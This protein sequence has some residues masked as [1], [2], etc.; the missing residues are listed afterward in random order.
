MTR[1]KLV[2]VFVGGVMCWLGFNE[3]TVGEGASPEPQPVELAELEAGAVPDNTHLEVGPHWRMYQELVF[4]YETKR[5][6]SEDDVT[7]STVVD[8]AYFPALSPSHPYFQSLGNLLTLYGDFD[9]IPEEQLPEVKQIALLV[10][11]KQHK[12]V[13]SLP[14][15]SWAQAESVR[16]LVINR[17]HELTDDERSL[18]EQS[19]PD[20][21]LESVLVLEEG[22][23]P[24]SAA[25][26]YGLMGGGAGVSLAGIGWLL[27]GFR[28]RDE[29]AVA[30]E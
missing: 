21:S 3:L 1:L 14:D 16:G 15:A 9:A 11:T 17:I 4:S 18:I 29:D 22:R 25:K 5:G 24:A 10:K 30:S 6:A 7:D 12:T 8:Y 27:V 20:L 28:R 26:V 19:F 13:G 23:A 2:L